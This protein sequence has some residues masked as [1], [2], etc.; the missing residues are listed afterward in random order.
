MKKFAKLLVL[1]VVAV[2]S[3]LAFV[4]CGF[5]DS[6]KPQSISL[7]KAQ[8]KI[9][10]G[11]TIQLANSTQENS[12]L[13]AKLGNT[14]LTYSVTEQV[15]TGEKKTETYTSFFKLADG[16]FERYSGTHKDLDGNSTQYYFDGSTL[17]TKTG[18]ED[19]AS[20]SMTKAAFAERGMVDV[21]YILKQQPKLLSEEGFDIYTSAQQIKTTAGINILL[22]SKVR[23][24]LEYVE[25]KTF[26]DDDFIGGP[27]E[28]AYGLNN[29]FQVTVS[30]DGKSDVIGLSI[31]YVQVV[32][33]A[34]GS[35]VSR[36][37]AI[38]FEKYI[39]AILAPEWLD[40]E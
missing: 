37:Y 26:N 10:A 38:T 28:V 15:G 14:K 2:L 5:N 23:A 32:E 16:E 39:D 6:K 13:F 4:G 36:T 21:D 7:A 1:P 29:T 30:F 8:Q 24:Y 12:D 31:N 33:G 27:Q 40:A 18:D 9:T 25:G 3:A 19:A 17:F 35:V 34:G 11:L 20:Q 22:Y